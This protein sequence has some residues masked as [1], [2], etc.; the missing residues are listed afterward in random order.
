VTADL[1]QS[2]VGLFKVTLTGAD[3]TYQHGQGVTSQ[4]VLKK[5]SQLGVPAWRRVQNVTT[6]FSCCGG[7]TVEYL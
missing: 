1:L 5:A 7:S 2:V 3:A 4:G 6:I